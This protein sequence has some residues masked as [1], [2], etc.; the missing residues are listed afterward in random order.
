MSRNQTATQSRPAERWVFEV[1]RRE[2]DSDIQSVSCPPVLSIR[3]IRL[4]INS[5]ISFAW[6]PASNHGEIGI[7]IRRVLA[8]NTPLPAYSS[9][10]SISFGVPRYLNCEC[11]N[12]HGAHSTCTSELDLER[13]EGSRSEEIFTAKFPEPAFARGCREGRSSSTWH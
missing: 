6:K 1:W 3:R 9:P 5:T 11:A 7:Q 10:R 12:R 2:W 8:K 4:V 13:G